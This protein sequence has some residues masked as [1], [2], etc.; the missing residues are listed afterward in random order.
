MRLASAVVVLFVTT[1]A[2]AAPPA[3]LDAIRAAKRVEAVRITTPIVIDG[4]LDDE[5]WTLATPT[6]DFYQ[7]QPAEFELATRRTEVRFLYDDEMLYVGA[8]LYEP[9]PERLITNELK[10]D[11]GGS[12]GDGSV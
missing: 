4:V 10:R 6:T 11:F 2:S 5:A 7:Q 9:Q 8:M 3:D 1:H 12:S